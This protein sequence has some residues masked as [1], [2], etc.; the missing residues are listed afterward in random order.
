MGV[1]A[2]GEKRVERPAAGAAK[3]STS[4]RREHKQKAHGSTEQRPEAVSIDERVGG[5]CAEEMQRERR[6][7]VCARAAALSQMVMHV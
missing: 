4:D 1:E 2:A 6:A 5:R 3:G 7:D